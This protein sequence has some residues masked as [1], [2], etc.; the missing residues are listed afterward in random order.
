VASL[1][2]PARGQ[3]RLGHLGLALGLLAA[4]ACSGAP[5]AGSPGAPSGAAPASGATP[6][7]SPAAPSGPA[8]AAPPAREKVRIAHV[9]NGAT[10]GVIDVARQAGMFDRYGID[11]ELQLIPNPIS[12]AAMLAGEVDF[13]FIAAQPIITSNLEGADTVLVSCGIGQAF[14]WIYGKPSIAGPADLKGK[15]I[16]NSRR[17]SDLYAVFNLAIQ[18][19]G[20]S[21]D[22]LTILQIDKDAEKIAAVASDAADAAVI[23][24]PTNVQAAR[25]GWKQIADV[26]DLGIPWPASCLATTERFVAERPAAVK[27]VI[28]AYIATT[29][30]MKAHREESIDMLTSFT[31]S[32]DRAALEAA[33][34]TLLKYQQAVPYPTIDGVQTILGSLENP[35]AAAASPERFVDDRV[36]RDL[37]TSGFI[38][39]LPD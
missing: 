5:A 8:A 38:R 4:V 26:G 39:S 1:P 24:V 14:W 13:N 31:G 10:M 20:L 6:P 22:D 29:R 11:A 2:G 37:D 27:G 18:R 16:A 28:E 23:S 12:V 7:A 36:V 35:A 32:D 21:P 33:Y 19:W 9:S 25:Q 34:D 30:W 3:R 15:R 17:G